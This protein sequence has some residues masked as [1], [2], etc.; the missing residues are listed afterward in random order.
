MRYV[1]I[2]IA[3]E[4]HWVAAVD[5]DEKLIQKATP[6]TEDATGYDKLRALLGASSDTLVAM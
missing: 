6:F 4:E 2:D 1:G 5:G 3:S